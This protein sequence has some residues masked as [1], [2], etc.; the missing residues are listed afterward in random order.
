MAL[1]LQIMKYINKDKSFYYKAKIWGETWLFWLHLATLLIRG[2]KFFKN[3][4]NS[5]RIIINC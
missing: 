2:V 4:S 1:Y 3:L 5:S